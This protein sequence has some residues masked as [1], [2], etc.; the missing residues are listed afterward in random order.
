MENL[1]DAPAEPA[2]EALEQPRA[3]TAEQPAPSRDRTKSSPTPKRSKPQR[4]DYTA[5]FSAWWDAYRAQASRDAG[6]PARGAKAYAAAR[7]KLSAEDLIAGLERYAAGR[8]RDFAA[9][10]WVK[11]TPDACNW[12]EREQWR[13]YPDA[14]V[15][16]DSSQGTAEDAA[17]AARDK[18]IEAR[19][20]PWSPPDLPADLSPEDYRAAVH[21]DKMDWRTASGRWERATVAA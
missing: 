2:A 7:R 3:V 9:A 20:G 4:H 8:A 12:L 11:A 1:E 6:S 19:V 13:D 18:K 14:P 15:T 17:R 21:A 5:E 16:A 10:G